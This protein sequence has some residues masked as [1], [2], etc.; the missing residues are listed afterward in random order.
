VWLALVA[1]VAAAQAAGVIGIPFTDRGTDSWYSQ[2]EV[3]PFNPPS[4]VFAPVW[5]TLYLLIGI[6]AWATWR[7]PDSPRRDR[8]LVAWWVQLALNAAWT[9]LFFGAQRPGWA[10]A[11]IVV[12][13][14]AAA[15]TWRWL[16]R[17]S[18]A[19][20]WLFAP[21]MAWISFAVVLNASI[22]GL[23]A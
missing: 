10:L 11:E 2:L 15:L 6:A 21:Y 16:A 20:A 13:W 18:T 22:V 1:F 19:S 7:R 4:W 8:A 3:P 14:L 23:N 9:P 12:L 17:C 5:T